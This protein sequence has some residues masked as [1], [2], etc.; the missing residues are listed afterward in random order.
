[1]L[2]GECFYP[3]LYIFN[4]YVMLSFSWWYIKFKVFWF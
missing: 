1:M 3:F 2:F 4:D